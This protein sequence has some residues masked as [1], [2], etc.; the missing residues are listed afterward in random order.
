MP[1]VTI[2]ATIQVDTDEAGIDVMTETDDPTEDDVENAVY[3]YF[4]GRANELAD[5]IKQQCDE[6][7]NY[8]DTVEVAFE[9]W[10]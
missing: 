9:E 1:I 7:K 2:T 5:L 8:Q 10:G 4:E 6:E 3:G